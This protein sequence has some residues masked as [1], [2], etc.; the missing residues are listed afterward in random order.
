[1]GMCKPSGGINEPMYGKVGQNIPGSFGPPNTRTDLYNIDNPKELLQQRW[2]GPDGR[3]L[4]DRDWKH[5]DSH[6]NHT[7]PHDHYWDWAKP[8][9]KQRPQ[10]EGPNGEDTNNSYC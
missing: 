7:F 3:N 9:G 10:Y 1:M 5:N 6:H 4:W 2:Y 8:P